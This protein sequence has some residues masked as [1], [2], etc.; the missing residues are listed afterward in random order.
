LISSD[1][2]RLC[3]FVMQPRTATISNGDTDMRRY[4]AQEP[5]PEHWSKDFVEH[6]RTVHFTL[7]TVSVGLIALLSS[8]TYDARKAASEMNELVELT[9]KPLLVAPRLK[10]TKATNDEIPYSRMFEAEAKGG[11]FQFFIDES[12]LYQCGTPGRQYLK[13][14]RSI[15][16]P[17]SAHT[18]RSAQAIIDS[19]SYAP[20]FAIETIRRTG[21]VKDSKGDPG[22]L[23]ITRSLTAINADHGANLRLA[24][25]CASG[26][27]KGLMD[28]ISDF[29]DDSPS[30]FQFSVTVSVQEQHPDK[31]FEIIKGYSSFQSRYRNLVE[32][33]RGRE[34]LDFS[35]LA[36]QIY[37]EVEKGDEPFEA[38]GLKIPENRIAG[39][40]IVVL[41]S[42]QLYFVMYL[43][44]LSNKLKPDDPGW[45]VPWMAMDQSKLARAMLFVSIV[46]LPACATF[47]VAARADTLGNSG[48]EE[49]EAIVVMCGLLLSWVLSLLSWTYRPK[50]RAPSVPSQLFE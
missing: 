32:A 9:T 24:V 30:T 50:L 28:G 45:D 23:I 10:A 42:I 29:G 4:S 13:P 12:N 6:L 36:P 11:V 22:A 8:K 33:A 15:S 49:I 2:T 26:T 14:L 31:V 40:G 20:L 34:D 18:L 17:L 37:A 48:G 3:F 43:R 1:V 21:T 16:S 46:L 27:V 35:I 44:R 25:D 47:A 41:I 7:V 38:F 39:W 19:W 5:N